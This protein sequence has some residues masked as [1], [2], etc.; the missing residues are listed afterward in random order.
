LFADQQ[1]LDTAF[2]VAINQNW[3]LFQ[4]PGIGIDSPTT[5]HYSETPNRVEGRI[6]CGTYKNLVWSKNSDLLLVEAQNPN[7]D[8]LHKWWLKF[9]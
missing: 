6:A 4:C 1:T 9:S 3:K 2:D 8:E 7:M 5:W